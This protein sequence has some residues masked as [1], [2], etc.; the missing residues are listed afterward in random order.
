MFFIFL[1]PLALLPLLTLFIKTKPQKFKVVSWLILFKESKVEKRWSFYVSII[2]LIRVSILA[3][4]I[5]FLSKPIP[6]K[7]KFD[8]ILFENS[9]VTEKEISRIR[10]YFKLLKGFFGERVECLNV[11]ELKEYCKSSVG[12]NLRVYVICSPFL[13]PDL[14]S[15]SSDLF[16]DTLMIKNAGIIDVEPHVGFDSVTVTFI[17][18]NLP[19]SIFEVRIESSGEV[20]YSDTLIMNTGE[21]KFKSFP[22]VHTLTSLKL[23][24]FPQ[25]GVDADNEVDIKVPGTLRSYFIEGENRVVDLFF[26]TFLIKAV[27]PEEADIIV[28]L[29]KIPKVSKK[30][31]LLVVFTNSEKVC[32][33]IGVRAKIIKNLQINGLNFNN[34]L[35]L[36]DTTF[37]SIDD[38]IRSS[39]MKVS[40]GGRD[41]IIVGTLPDFKSNEVLYYPLFW[42]LLLRELKLWYPVSYS[43][44]RE[45]IGKVV[46][47]SLFLLRFQGDFR[48]VLGVQ[49]VRK[50][51]LP[52]MELSGYIRKFR[53]IFI[54]ALS[55]LIMLELFLYRKWFY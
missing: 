52:R 17:N 53:T 29:N 19:D 55:I 30:N 50:K 27:S 6:T 22:I 31:K 2:I 34:V 13:M 51:Y 35:A 32:D 43:Y 49:E 8:K 3:I 11:K 48:Q 20:V 47:D 1:L 15:A 5:L 4:I 23:Q 45:K 46:N 37:N 14:L 54:L 39:I 40:S 25:D 9:A 42:S 18:Y 7:Y 21:T 28:S 38:F 10:S 36:K 24:L 16:W 41:I 44:E 26:N 12:K 33:A